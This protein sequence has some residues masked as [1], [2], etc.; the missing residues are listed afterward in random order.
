MLFSVFG[1]HQEI[2]GFG[3]V[4]ILVRGPNQNGIALKEWQISNPQTHNGTSA[5]VHAVKNLDTLTNSMFFDL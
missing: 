4:S 3:S 2:D 5:F 1:I